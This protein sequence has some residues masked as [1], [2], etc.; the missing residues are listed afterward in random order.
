MSAFM[1]PFLGMIATL[2]TMA[3]TDYDVDSEEFDKEV[4]K[5]IPEVEKELNEIKDKIDEDDDD[6]DDDD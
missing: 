5:R 3:K 6:D 2:E 1:K 4:A